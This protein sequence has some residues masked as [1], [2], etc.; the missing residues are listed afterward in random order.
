MARC[1]R[2]ARV[3]KVGDEVDDQKGGCTY[4]AGDEVDDKKGGWKIHIRWVWSWMIR[5]RIVGLT[6][7][8]EVVERCEG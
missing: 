3:Y 1:E 6:G 5:I 2:R 4:K 8:A 7:E